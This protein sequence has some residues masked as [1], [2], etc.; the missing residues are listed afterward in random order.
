[1]IHSCTTGSRHNLGT[2][3][4]PLTIVRTSNLIV[5]AHL[6][7]KVLHCLFVRPSRLMLI[8]GVAPGQSSKKQVD[9][10]WLLSV[11]QLLWFHWKVCD[12]LFPMQFL[13]P[14]FS[15]L[16]KFPALLLSTPFLLRPI[17]HITNNLQLY[18]I[19]FP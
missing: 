14:N 19:L 4:N 9:W 1:M 13:T 10:C 6:S 18:L 7:H 3:G 8:T 17:L 16:M 15:I 11:G 2:H 5:T 12:V